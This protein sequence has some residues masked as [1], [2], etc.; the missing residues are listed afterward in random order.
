MKT[1]FQ[2]NY[3]G[4]SF[5]PRLIGPFSG[6]PLIRKSQGNFIFLQG[7]GIVRE[8]CKMVREILNTKKRQGKV[9]EFPNFGP[10]LF[11]SGRYFIRLERLKP[12]NFFFFFLLASLTWQYK[13]LLFILENVCP[14]TLKHLIF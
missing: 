12:C 14:K 11:G 6:W 13:E 7:Q 2:T 1:I 5:F 4:L 3:L 10:K 9:W 8:F